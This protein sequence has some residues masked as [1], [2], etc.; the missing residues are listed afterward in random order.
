MEKYLDDIYQ[1]LKRELIPGTEKEVCK[2]ALTALTS[3][4]HMLSSVPVD[5]DEA[6]RLH[7]MLQK[8]IQGLL[9]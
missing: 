6:V 8:V 2:E 5:R 1:T 3:L 4:I 9:L 7:T